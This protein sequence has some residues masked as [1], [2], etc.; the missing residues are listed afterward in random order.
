MIGW[1][2]AT[3]ELSTPAFIL[4]AILF[5]WQIPHFLALA[6]LYREDYARGGFAMLPVIDR[7]GRITCQVIVV[8]MLLLMATALMA[9]LANIAGPVYAIGSLII[10]AWMFIGID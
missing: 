9:T 6:W 7:E 8:S 1:V 3:D 2:A 10:G 5:V 4:G